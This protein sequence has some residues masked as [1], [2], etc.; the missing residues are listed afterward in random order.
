LTVAIL[1]YWV[2]WGRVGVNVRIRLTWNVVVCAAWYG[3]AILLCTVYSL[4]G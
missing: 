1:I 4:A 3:V 2:A